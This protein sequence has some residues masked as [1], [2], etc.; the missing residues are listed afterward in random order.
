MTEKEVLDEAK[1]RMG[2]KCQYCQRGNRSGEDVLL[3]TFDLKEVEWSKLK[4]LVDPDKMKTRDEDAKA[5]GIL[6]REYEVICPA[7]LAKHE[8]GEL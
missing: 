1:R 8:L 6:T 7:C 3:R 5:Q 4:P 2:L